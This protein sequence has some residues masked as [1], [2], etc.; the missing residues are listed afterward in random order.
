[1]KRR[2]KKDLFLKFLALFFAFLLWFFVVLQEKIEREISLNLRIVDLPPNTLLLKVKP[3][4]L[5]LKVIGPRSILRNLPAE[6]PVLQLD[7]SRYPPGRHTLRIPIERIKLPSGL[8]VV[9]VIPQEAEVWLDS[10]VQKWI[11]VKVDLRGA[12]PEGGKV[13]EVRIRPRSVRVKGA[14]SVLKDLKFIYTVPVSIPK[15]EAG[16][17]KVPLS[18]PEGVVEVHPE[19]VQVTIKVGRTKP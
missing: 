14:R 17:L 9:E 13:K 11:R 7:L 2:R 18:I 15:K 10:L 6:P 5:R 12:L 8:K 4:T 19:K 16:T 3:S 1:M